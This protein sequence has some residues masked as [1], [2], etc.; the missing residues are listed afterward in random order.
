MD[1]MSSSQRPSIVERG[2]RFSVIYS[3]HDGWAIG[4]TSLGLWSLS[5]SVL[6]AIVLRRLRPPGGVSGAERAGG[7]DP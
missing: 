5:F 3:R 4:L 2:R 7:R 6:G 1:W